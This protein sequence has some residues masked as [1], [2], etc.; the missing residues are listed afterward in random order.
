MLTSWLRN[1]TRTQPPT[2]LLPDLE[3]LAWRDSIEWVYGVAGPRTRFL[4]SQE[5]LRTLAIESMNREGIVAEFGVH[6]GK[7]IR[8]LSTVM[9]LLGDDRPIFGFDSWLGFSEDWTGVEASY[10]RELFSTGGVLPDLPDRVKPIQGFIEETAPPFFAD[11]P[12]GDSIALAHI[13]TDTHSPARV[14]LAS[15][16]PYFIEGSLI[17]FD[18]FCGYPNWRS[19]E[20]KALAEVV[21][22]DAIDWL[23]FATRDLSSGRFIK[24]LCRVTSL[25]ATTSRSLLGTN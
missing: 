18:E 15:M 14:A 19:H 8:H 12:Q 3:T 2:G 1:I 20:Y 13:D 22:L 24:A 17:L 6:R 7:S 4:E 25:E 23:G 16:R 5:T 10:T 21:G 11:L 9:D